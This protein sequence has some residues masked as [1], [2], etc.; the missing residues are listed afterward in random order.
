MKFIEWMYV[1]DKKDILR[2]K[3][4][5]NKGSLNKQGNCGMREE[6]QWVG[7]ERESGEEW[8]HSSSN[9]G[10]LTNRKAEESN[11]TSVY[12]TLSS[13]YFLHLFNLERIAAALNKRSFIRSCKK[14][15]DMSCWMLF[16]FHLFALF[17]AVVLS[18]CKRSGIWAVGCWCH[19]QTFS[20]S[21]C[22]TSPYPRIH[23]WR[24]KRPVLG[25]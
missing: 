24:C 22:P 9:L 11:W 14:K 6:W 7:I 8:G 10:F 16:L 21:G 20:L 1:T 23:Q 12:I 2:W 13:S 19:I 17:V 5:A 25:R 3:R 18:L 15:W 4:L